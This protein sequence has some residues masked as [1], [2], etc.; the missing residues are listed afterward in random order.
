MRALLI[1]ARI[2][3]VLLLLAGTILLASGVLLTSSSSGIESRYLPVQA[4]LQMHADRLATHIQTRLMEPPLHVL[5][6][7]ITEPFD[8]LKFSMLGPTPYLGSADLPHRYAVSWSQADGWLSDPPPDAGFLEG[9]FRHMAHLPVWKTPTMS[10]LVMDPPERDHPMILAGTWV[11]TDDNLF[12]HGALTPVNAFYSDY[13]P[14]WFEEYRKTVYGQLLNN[15]MWRPAEIRLVP[16]NMD[17][18]TLILHASRPVDVETDVLT[19]PAD[20]TSPLV[21]SFFATLQSRMEPEP[22]WQEH[23]EWYVGSLWPMHDKIEVASPLRFDQFLMEHA[24]TRTTYGA[25]AIVLALILLP[26]TW[27]KRRKTV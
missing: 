11:K 9:R 2:A 20:D 19:D 10:S 24:R 6:D 22:G 14:R 13:V 15:W 3:V 4:S 5:P 23:A 25:G 16:G 27:W 26:F 17:L 8:S 18:D 1:T 7:P 21:R 12:F